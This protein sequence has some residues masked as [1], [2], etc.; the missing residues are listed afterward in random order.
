MWSSCGNLVIE[1][2]IT[3][4]MFLCALLIITGNTDLYFISS[5]NLINASLFSFGLL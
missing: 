5:E 4:K 1:I 2:R 3:F